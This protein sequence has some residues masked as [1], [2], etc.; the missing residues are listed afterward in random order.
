MPG[1]ALAPIR[2]RVQHPWMKPSP[3]VA[4]VVSVLAAGAVRAQDP[5]Q[6]WFPFAIPV[7]ADRAPAFDLRPLNEPTAGA[8]GWLRAEG[9][10]FID[11]RGDTVRLFG[12]NLTAAACFP[13]PAQAGPLARHLARLGCNIVRLHFLDNQWGPGVP[14]LVPPSNNPGRDGLQADALARL[15][16]FLAELK[17]AGVRVNLN[18]HVGRHYPGWQE[19][20]PQF[21]KGTGQFLPGDIA[22]LKTYARLLLEHVNPHTGIALKDDPAIPILEISN[23]DSLVNDP[24]WATTAPEPVAGELRR[25]WNKWLLDNQRDAAALRRDW[26]EYTG[27]TGPELAPPL[28]NWM[29]ERHGGSASTLVAAEGANTVRWQATQPGQAAWHIQLNSGKLPVDP[30][31]C[32]RVAFRAR[33]ETGNRITLS[34][35]QAGGAWENLGLGEELGLTG[36]WQEFSFRWFPSRVD[37]AAGSRFVLS[38]ANKTGLVDLAA[39]SCREDSPGYLLAGQTPEAGTIPLPAAGAPAV[40]RRDY[41]AFLAEVEIKFA[42]TIRGFLK[43]ELGCKALVADTQVMFGGVLGARREGVVSDFIDNHGYWHHPSWPN[44]PW[45]P[46]D[47]TIGNT[48]QITHPEGGTLGDLAVAR[49]SGKPY[50]VS[51]YDLPAPSDY[52]AEMWPMLAA[53]ASFQGWA[54]LYHYTFAHRPDDFTADRI[55]GYFNGAVHPAKDGLR[56]A[57]ALIHRLGL[58]APSRA[59]V[60]VRVGDVDLLDIATRLNGSLWGSWASV[61]QATGTRGSELVLRNATAVTIDP[62]A[63]GITPAP[64]KP[65]PL[66]P[67]PVESDTGE[68]SWDRGKGV[69]I[70]RAPAAR[71]WCG[72][73]GGQTLAALDATLKTAALPGPVP[74]ATV[75]LVATDGKPLAGSRQLLVTAMRRAENKGMGWNADRTSVSDRWGEGPVQ[76]LGLE[77]EL[78]LPG[79]AGWTVTPLD[80]SGQRR[81]AVARNAGSVH[82]TPAHQ[83]IWWIVEKE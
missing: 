30:S 11:E 24:W 76:V 44:K 51:E 62:A 21:S 5:A 65:A 32:Y 78:A 67:G 8:N 27:A 61:W 9:E 64:A 63:K 18:L 72:S 56:P 57:A 29:V 42:R 46:K 23:E 50:T 13:D 49:P 20:L 31:K 53:V 17:A 70:L 33:S 59:R 75:V 60:V 4:C 3:L 19:P 15:D 82:I 39:F 71:A 34:A 41:L 14:S 35:T 58:V 80:A 36:G 26:G 83:T 38:L 37:P 10:R 6:G 45:D 43:E 54:G 2:V 79:G 40:V 48:S 69:W 73:I 22:E 12:T 16:R 77:A 7:L 68:W 28:A 66:P 25:Q 47:W 55:T 1:S 74:H 52:A 81:E